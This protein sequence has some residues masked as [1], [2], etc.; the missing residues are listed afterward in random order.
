VTTLQTAD[1]RLLRAQRPSGANGAFSGGW[2]PT[3][4]PPMWSSGE[5]EGDEAWLKSYEAIYRSQPNLAAVIDKLTRRIAT[6]PFDAYRRLPN[7][8]REMMPSTDSLASLIARPMNRTSRV[9]LL[10]HIIQSL[11]IHGNAVVAKLHTTGDR[12]APPDQLWPL[13][14][15]QM[16]AYGPTGGRIEWWSTTQFDNVERFIS[17]DD[18]IH[19]AWP[20]PKGGEVGVSPLEKLGVTIRLEDAAQRH[21]TALFRNGTRPSLSV[22]IDSPTG[23]VKPELLEYARERVEAMHKGMDRAGGTFFTGANVKLQPLSLSPVEVALIEQRNLNLGEIGRV[24][25]LSGPVMND[26]EHGTYSNVQVLLDALYRDV[27]PVWLGLTEQT[28]Q[29]QLIDPEPAWLDRFLAFDL[30]DKLKG[31]PVQLAQSLKLQVEAGLITRNEARRI[32]NLPP[33]EDPSADTL[34]MNVNNQA[35]IGDASASPDAAPPIA[36]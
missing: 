4:F 14:W 26:L 16:S 6:L 9:H 27:V 5:R 29:A 17:V 23:N 33:S 11:L 2:M 30:T 15:A 34:T 13:D 7:H 12:E 35:P 20:D 19:F 31:D 36:P 8:A 24:F 28:F 32:L 18:T 10:A 3:S 1:G 22:S 25:D 21:Q